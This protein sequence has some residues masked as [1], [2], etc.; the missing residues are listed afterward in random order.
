[1]CQGQCQ[2]DEGQTEGQ[3]QRQ[4]KETAGPN[5]HR[6]AQVYFPVRERLDQVRAERESCPVDANHLAAVAPLDVLTQS[7]VGPA[8]CDY[9]QRRRVAAQRRREA[10]SGAQGWVMAEAL[11]ALA[12]CFATKE[13]LTMREATVRVALLKMGRR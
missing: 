9:Q 4:R 1:M 8:R 7:R 10:D 5:Q 3:R 11:A 6:Q 2:P 13:M 12:A